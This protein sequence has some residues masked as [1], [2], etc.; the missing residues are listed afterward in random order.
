MKIYESL[1]N[2]LRTQHQAIENILMPLEPARLLARPQPDKWNILENVAHLGRYQLIFIERINQI[3]LTEEPS[4]GRYIAEED[5][6]FESW[7]PLPVD[8]LL[9][10]IQT[11]R[12]TIYS[13][14]T[15]LTDAAQCRT[16]IHKKFGRLTVLQWAEFFLLHEAHHLYTIFQLANDP[17]LSESNTKNL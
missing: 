3:L 17:T 10:Q 8:T 11:D 5:P 13:L 16:G 12:N 15:N 7:K 2:R 6:E 9:R 4:F 14:I 1:N